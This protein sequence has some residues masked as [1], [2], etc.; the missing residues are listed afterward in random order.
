M[1]VTFLTE[2]HYVVVDVGVGDLVERHGGREV[3]VV[4]KSG[5]FWLV[6]TALKG[7]EGGRFRC[8]LLALTKPV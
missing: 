3:L 2:A 4:G 6:F 8:F 1:G 7:L 5:L